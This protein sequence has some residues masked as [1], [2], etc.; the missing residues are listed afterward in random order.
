MRKL[1]I[2]LILFLS[3]LV[4]SPGYGQYGADLVP[5]SNRF[6]FNI[7]KEAVND[8]PNT[9]VVISPFSLFYALGMTYNGAG[10]ETEKAMRNVLCYGSLENF[11]INYGYLFLNDN[12]KNTKLSVII[13]I[14]NSIWHDSKFLVRPE[15]TNVIANK[16][17]ADIMPVDFGKPS[18]CDSINDWIEDKTHGKIANMLDC[19]IDRDVVMYLINTIFFKGTWAVE[20]DEKK[21]RPGAFVT[22]DSSKVECLMM[23]QKSD[24][25]YMKRDKF[26]VIDLP[27]GE[28]GYSMAIFLPSQSCSVDDLLAEFN[29]KNWNTWL[30]KIDN[31]SELLLSLPKFKV[32]YSNDFVPALA[33]LGMGIAFSSSADFSGITPGGGI[34]INRVLHNTF[35]QVDEQG[36]EAAAATIVEMKLGGRP[37]HMNINRPFIFV[38]HDDNSGAILFMGKIENPVWEEG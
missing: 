37:R 12:M 13:N 35:V 7:F 2:L 1:I 6:A 26:E 5:S 30:P 27:Y 18:T 19:P 11:Q 17:F 32:K 14:K 28:S 9:N 36:T 34:F 8:T 4:I 24:F 3:T 21:T 29:D 33:R 16:F 10:G 20:F 25:A 23:N 38:I 31:K 15:F 22:D